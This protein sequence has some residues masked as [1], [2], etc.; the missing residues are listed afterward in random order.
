MSKRKKKVG[1][2]SVLVFPLVAGIAI[3]STLITYPTDHA[4]PT[5]PSDS[6]LFASMTPVAPEVPEPEVMFGINV[7]SLEVVEAT[8][9]PNE[10]LSQILRKYNIS[11]G[12]IDR[13]AKKSRAVFDVRKIRMDK[14]YTVLCRADSAHTAQY[15]IYEPNR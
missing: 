6:V 1:H 4:L 12:L 11:L 8:I 15:F 9:Q 5:V 2:L 3:Y 7:D 13:I 14:D 10:Y